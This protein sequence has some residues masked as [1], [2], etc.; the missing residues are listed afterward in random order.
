MYQEI[1]NKF[2]ENKFT[3][4]I[5]LA[6][7]FHKDNKNDHYIC[8]I[9][10][11]IYNKLNNLISTEEYLLKAIKIKKEKKYFLSLGNLYLQ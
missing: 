9:I 6:L 2:T 3:E 1:K 8:F 11:E 5:N 7:K 10:G 4:A